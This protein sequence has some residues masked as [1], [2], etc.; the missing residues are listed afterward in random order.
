M[1]QGKFYTRLGDVAD[2]LGVKTISMEDLHE[3]NERRKEIAEK[4]GQ[5]DKV[6]FMVDALGNFLAGFAGVDQLDYHLNPEVMMKAQLKARERFWGLIW[7]TVAPDFGVALEP[8][9]IGGKVVWRKDQAPIAVQSFDLGDADRVQVKKPREVDVIVKALETYEYFK[10]N[11]PEGVSVDFHG[12]VLGPIDTSALVTGIPIFME[13]LHRKPQVV[14]R[15]LDKVT[16]ALISLAELQ[17]EVTGKPRRFSVNDDYAGHLSPKMFREFVIPYVR[18]IY[19]ILPSDTVR[20]F[21]SDGTQIDPCLELLPEMGVQVFHSFTF[22]VDLASAKARIGS[23][24]CLSGNMNPID[25]IRNGSPGSVLHAC[26]EAIRKA[27]AGGGYILEA[28]GEL[29]RGTPCENIDAMIM[30]AL[31]YGSYPIE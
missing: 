20:W 5:P 14:H 15:L 19:E 26:H 27:A 17:F 2:A 6:P 13:S 3:R 23:S 24:V 25:V 18:R 21:H 30:A 22:N 16:D 4:L 7:G 8:S 10:K 1:L 31:E 28:G 29:G 9:L 12:A 11:A